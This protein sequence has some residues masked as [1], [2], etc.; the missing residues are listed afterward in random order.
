[1]S[2]I[3]P[4]FTLSSTLRQSILAGQ[5][6]L[7]NDE[8]ELTTGRDADV[9]LTLGAQTGQS[10]TLRS[11]DS[12]LQTIEASN[13]TASTVLSSTQ[14]ILGSL[15]TT[16]QSFLNS[17][18]D[19]NGGSAP[20]AQT[21]QTTAM[22]NLQGLVSQLNT[23]V[24]GQFIFGGINSSVPPLTEF[25][26]GSANQQAVAAAFEGAFGFS[27]SDPNVSSITSAQMQSFLTTQFSPLFQGTSWEGTW[28]SASD[29]PVASQIS[30]SQTVVTSVSANQPAFQELAQAYTTM[31]DLGTANLGPDAFQTAV[32][33]AETLL[34]Q[35]ITGL[36][37]IGA[38]L[39]TTQ[40]AITSANNFMSTQANTLT[41]QIGNLENV[42]PLAV[43]SQE[44]DLQ[45]QI[46]TAFELT[47]QLQQL[48]L[49]K[50]L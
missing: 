19:T 44:S 35:A 47:S 9:G 42:D 11:Q 10:V 15:Q 34:Q 32:S 45:T 13:N 17:L 48:S 39:G 38:G 43:Q 37:N 7:S 22:T 1:M 8:V 33:S 25:T 14:T 46:E 29:T 24:A 40:Q 26:S 23:N 50:F 2:S 28:S 36:T 18:L 3:V 41:T 31:A 5:A 27:Q 30:P 21:T 4:S 6:T 20:S 16:A 12:L 49:V